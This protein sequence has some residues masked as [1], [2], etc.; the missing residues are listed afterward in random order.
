MKQQ[1][2]LIFPP[3][4]SRPFTLNKAASFTQVVQNPDFSGLDHLSKKIDNFS[5]LRQLL[6]KFATFKQ[7]QR[8]I[9]NTHNF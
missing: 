4:F 5:Q 8:Q 3:V 9:R 2:I 7:E 6:A 1:S